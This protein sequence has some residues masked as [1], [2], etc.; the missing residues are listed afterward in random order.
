MSLLLKYGADV[1]SVDR[2]GMCALFMAAELG[3]THT[4]ETLLSF[5]PDLTLRDVVSHTFPLCVENGN[6][7]E[8]Y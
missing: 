7:N 8:L 1:N 4:V 3:D 2:N 5:Q 6:V